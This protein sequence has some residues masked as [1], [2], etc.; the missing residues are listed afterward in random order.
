MHEL[1]IEGGSLIDVLKREIYPCNIGIRGGKITTLSQENLD[2]VKKIDG[3]GKLISPGFID[4][5]M[6]EDPIVLRGNSLEIKEDI[7]KT[8]AKMGVTTCIG[9]NCGIGMTDLKEYFQIVKR[10]GLPVNFGSYLGYSA[11]REKI[12]ISDNYRACTTEEILKINVLLE[13]GLDEGALGISF[14][15]EYTPGSTTNEIIEVAKTLTGRPGKLLSAHFRSDADLGVEAL[16]ELIYISSVVKIPMQISHIGS[17]TG[18]GMMEE[19]LQLLERARA[20]E[21]DIMADCY[22]YE[23]FSTYI[24]SAVFDEG[25]FQRWNKSYDALLATGG[26]KKGMECTKE[27]FEY[28][29]KEEPNTLVVAFVMEA[30]EIEKAIAHPYVMVAS[31]G[32]LQNSQGHPRAAGSFP[33]VLAHYVKKKQVLSLMD[34][35]TKMT[36]MPA[37]RLGLTEKGAIKIGSDADLV[38]F[39]FD[40]IE[41]KATFEQPVDA[42]V[43]I[44]HVIVSGI[45]VVNDG[46]FTKEKPGKTISF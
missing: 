11:L 38:I 22:P 18:Y 36:L 6:H 44:S 39:D 25:C 45:S 40:S 30:E 14:G 43:G 16:K 13:K 3:R 23:A 28:L 5:H 42:P 31:D 12:G 20:E 8:M 2:G 17:C 21:I 29:R 26:K 37:K 27:I 19:G 41:D 33:R 7:F 34:A 15:L 10:D 4:I 1:V 32:L 46:V 35:I 24:G 9:G